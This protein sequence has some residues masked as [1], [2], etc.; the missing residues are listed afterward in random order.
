M[1]C[2]VHSERPAE[3]ICTRCYGRL[4][5][6][7]CNRYHTLAV[8]H[9]TENCKEVGCALLRQRIHEGGGKLAK[10]MVKSMKH[11]VKDMLATLLQEIERFR[12]SCALTEEIRKMKQLEQEGRYA[13]LYFCVTGLHRDGDGAAKHMDAIENL[14]KRFVKTL[15]AASDQLKAI[16]DKIALVTA[17]TAVPQHRPMLAAYKR[18]EVFLLNK[19]S[20]YDTEEKIVAALQNLKRDMPGQIR[21]VFISPA[22]PVGNPVALELASLLET[23][24]ISALY[25][26]GADISDMGAKA[27]A[28]TAFRNQSLSMFC[29]DAGKMT[30][31]GVKAVADAARNSR[32]LTTLYLWGSEIS[33]TGAKAVANAVKGCPISAFGIWSNGISDVGATDLAEM[34]HCCCRTLSAFFLGSMNVSADGTKKMADAVRS[35]R[36]MSGLYFWGKPLS[37]ETLEYILD[38]MSGTISGVRSVNLQIGKGVSERQMENC[39]T[40]LQRNGVG[41]HLKLRF[42]CGDNSAKSVCERCA[43]EFNGEVAEFRIVQYIPAL[44]VD[45]MILGV[46]L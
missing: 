6:E 20:E 39:L 31:V 27:L 23:A 42:L 29:L 28:R 10:K 40:K 35:C 36:L 2:V 13:E 25:L 14:N 4:L 38:A 46:S 1:H 21:A 34:M 37:G 26:S 22:C 45:E 15:D 12:L 9:S 18:D 33:D 7:D 32:S 43:T 16:R 41:K 44:F 3:Y 30:E 8:P 24:P 17:T 11:I 5:C 19:A